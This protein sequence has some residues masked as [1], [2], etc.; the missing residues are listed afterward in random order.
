MTPAEL[1]SRI[2]LHELRTILLDDTRE[3]GSIPQEWKD[4]LLRS[5]HDPAGYLV[6]GDW[7]DDQGDP[8]GELCRIQVEL[9]DRLP[10]E[11]VMS[12][13]PSWTAGREERAKFQLADIAEANAI[14]DQMRDFL[15]DE[16]DFQL[17]DFGKEYLQAVEENQRQTRDSVFLHLDAVKNRHHWFRDVPAGTDLSRQRLRHIAD[18][19]PRTSRLGRTTRMLTDVLRYCALNQGKLIAIV[20]NDPGELHKRF[21][22]VLNEIW[23]FKPSNVVNLTAYDVNQNYVGFLYNNEIRDAADVT[24]TDHACQQYQRTITAITPESALRIDD[25][26][27]CGH[28]LTEPHECP[29]ASE[30]HGDDRLCTC[31]DSCAHECARDI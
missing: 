15:Y 31:C 12:R 19:Y 20:H 29:Y 16:I 5:P 30:I 24:F 22:H 14:S 9:I 11:P 4:E 21:A 6:L 10:V 8:L 1:H 7:L 27:H 26:H 3:G 17:T 18:L 13:Q 23:T 2:L 25:L 28:E